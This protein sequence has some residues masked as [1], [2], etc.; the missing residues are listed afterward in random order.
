MIQPLVKI[1]V[2]FDVG[3]PSNSPMKESMYRYLSNELACDFFTSPNQCCISITF[4]S[5]I[6]H[7]KRHCNP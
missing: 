5:Y 3:N 1:K 4:C 2:R 7:T 6:G